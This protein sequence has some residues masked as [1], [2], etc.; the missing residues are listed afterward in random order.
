LEEGLHEMAMTTYQSL[1]LDFTP[2][3]IRTARE[4]RRALSFIEQHMRPHPPKAESELLELLSTLVMDYESRTFPAGD[5]SAGEMLAHLID[6]RGVTKAEVARVT[7]IPRATITS[8]ISGHRGI[9][10]AVA[11]ALANY[12]HVSPAVFLPAVR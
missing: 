2:R 3:P 6:A 1:L 12:F 4:Y 7:G 9:S 11:V 8:A 5:V 10:K